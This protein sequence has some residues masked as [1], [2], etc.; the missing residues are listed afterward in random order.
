MHNWDLMGELR[1][2]RFKEAEVTEY[3]ALAGIWHH[4]D[5]QMK[6]GL[7]Y[8]WGDVSD[9]LRSLEGRKSGVFFN[10]VGSF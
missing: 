4:V 1:S 9:D 2:M 7:G 6:L 5:P 10:I 3:G 8:Q